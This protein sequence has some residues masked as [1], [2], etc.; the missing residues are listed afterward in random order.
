MVHGAGLLKE[1][2]GDWHFSYFIF[3]SFLILT[4]KNYFTKHWISNLGV[5]CSK[6][7]GGSKVNSAFHPSEV[8]KMSTRIIWEFS[9][10]K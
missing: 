6:L 7:L 5:L 3:S 10:K 1:G 2:E 9:G 4:F 8:D